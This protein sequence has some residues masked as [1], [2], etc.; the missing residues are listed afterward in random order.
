MAHKDKILIV[1]DSDIN[2]SLLI[3]ILSHQYDIVEVENGLEAIEYM[4]KHIESI[5][6]VLLDIVMPV[7]DGF[8]VLTIMNHNQWIQSTPVIMITS[9]TASQYINKAYD[10]GVTDYIN[11]P[12]DELTV[13]RRVNNTIILYA[14]QKMLEN[15]VTEQILEKEKNNLLMVEIL[16][17][18]VEFR[19]GESGLH[20]LRIRIITEFLMQ[21]L[22]RSSDQYSFSSSY[23]SKVVNASALHDIGKIMIPET[24]LNKP[25]KLTKEEFKVIQTHS[26]LGAQ[27]LENVPYYQQ[28]DLIQIAHDICRWHHERYDG[29]GYPDGLI[30]DDIPFAAQVVALADVYD[31]LT[32]QRVY[33][34]AFTHERAMEMIKNGECGCFNPELLECFYNSGE[35]LR[36]KLDTYSSHQLL[37]TESQNVKEQLLKNA[38]VSNRTLALLEQ[39]R[40]KY[41]FFASMSGEI[42]FEYDINSDI[43]SLSE[44]GAMHLCIPEIIVKPFEN[45]LIKNIIF[46]DSLDK[47]KNKIELATLEKPIIEMMARMNIKGEHRWMKILARPLWL[48]ETHEMINVIGKCV[49][50][51]EEYTKMNHL[52][53]IANQDSLTKLL[54]HKAARDQIELLMSKKNNSKYALVLIDLDY[55]KEANDHFGHMFGDDVLRYVANELL[56]N[57]NDESIVSRVGGDEFMLFFKYDKDIEGIMRKLHH[58]IIREYKGYSIALCM[59]IALYPQ[60]GEVYDDIYNRADQALYVAKNNGRK[61]YRFYAPY[62]HEKQVKS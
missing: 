45:S 14:K 19:N 8:E 29:K 11:R 2:R 15:M 47:L 31:A 9:E 53:I 44:W 17:H 20:V 13:Q 27:M 55:F 38:S 1:D 21:E 51:H 7:M 16:S 5:S 30:G 57:V 52:E 49:D 25:G 4:G 56:R 28:E 58:A 18:I 37:E 36:Q 10:L 46:K 61:Q 40:T 6:L 62:S 26:A 24:I 34:P 35:K 59:G 50:I 32:S 33:K 39:E 60:D 23:I 22:S 48:E 43:L 42:Q 41:R 3:D 12:F 54:N